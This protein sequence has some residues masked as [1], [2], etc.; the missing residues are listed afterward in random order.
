M[1]SN[2]VVRLASLATDWA[3]IPSRD[4]CNVWNHANDLGRSRQSTEITACCVTSNIDT[5]QNANFFQWSER[6]IFNG[7]ECNL[8]RQLL[9]HEV[10]KKA[11][12]QNLIVPFCILPFSLAYKHVS[13]VLVSIEPL[14]SI[15]DWDSTSLPY[16]VQLSLH[17]P[18][19]S[20]SRSW[21]GLD[22]LEIRFCFF[23][24]AGT[25]LSSSISSILFWFY[26]VIKNLP[27]IREV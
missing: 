14:S 11:F 1:D 17:P 16:L 23:N 12:L 20:V 18:Q 3:S 15:V 26:S 22:F 27:C 13:I 4:W 2:C 21:L 10:S 25:V 9:D 19:S 24:L 8:I 7:N 6:E 5:I